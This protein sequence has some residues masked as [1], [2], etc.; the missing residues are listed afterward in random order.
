MTP[1][2]FAVRIEAAVL[3]HLE[4]FRESYGYEPDANYVRRLDPDSASP[5]DGDLGFV[6]PVE[7]RKF[8]RAVAE[9]SLPDV[10]NGYFL[11]PPDL[12]IRAWRAGEPRGRIVVGSDGGGALYVVR[13]EDESPVFRMTDAFDASPVRV[14]ATFDGFLV[15][16]LDE[17]EGFVDEAQPP[18]L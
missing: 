1:S 18:T 14:A 17:I 10:W 13:P 6:V 4:G 12:G 5:F 15:R 11:G 2:D 16:L 8:F 7:V 9:V 3:R